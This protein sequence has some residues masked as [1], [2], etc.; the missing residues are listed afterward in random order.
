MWIS[1]FLM[2]KWTWEC[3]LGL[4]FLWHVYHS[5]AHEWM[6]GNWWWVQ[7]MDEKL[8]SCPLPAWRWL[9]VIY[10]FPAAAVTKYQNLSILKQHKCTVSQFWRADV[11]NDGVAKALP[12][13]RLWVESFLA[14]RGAGNL[15][16]AAA[17]F[18]SLPLS[19]RACSYVSV[20]LSYNHPSH[21]DLGPIL[22]TYLNLITSV[23]K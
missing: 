22:W 1:C 23:L 19:P 7:N 3:D 10:Q 16:P 18:Q 21:T 6:N 14:S 5:H 4:Y 20:S 13:W 12:P 9:G 2:L 8:R 17:S 15:W 11:Q